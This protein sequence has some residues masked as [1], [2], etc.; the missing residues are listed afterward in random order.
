MERLRTLDSIKN[1]HM[2][3]IYDNKSGKL[4][5][6][7]KI[8]EGSGNA[9]YGLEVAKA[10]DLDKEFIDLANTIRKEVLQIDK[11]VQKTTSKYN[12]KVVID[13]CLI[14]KQKA[15]EV[16]HIKPQRVADKFNRIGT[17]HKNVEHNLITLC[18]MCH[19][20]VENGDLDI[21][22]YTQTSNGIEVQ[23]RK[24]DKKELE[25][26]K[27]NRKKYNKEQM[28]IIMGYREKTNHN[29]SKS[30]KLLEI[31]YE[32][33]VSNHIIKKIWCGEY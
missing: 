6:N 29:I 7:R 22:G 23:Y 21:T 33:K 1:Y 20:Q 8:K 14:C 31:D 4:I 5:Y 26:K 18:H 12:A 25:R 9:I 19:Q 32:I 30:R 11:V 3:T 16:H 17:H 28:D 27:Q 10:M 13:T 24:I 15:T 2:E